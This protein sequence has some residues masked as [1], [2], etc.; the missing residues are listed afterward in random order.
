MLLCPVAP[1]AALKIDESG[2][3]AVMTNGGEIITMVELKDISPFVVVV[4]P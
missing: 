1:S 3:L 2:G 4:A